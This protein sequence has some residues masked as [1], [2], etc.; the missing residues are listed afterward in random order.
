MEMDNG[1]WIMDNE[2]G[3]L[4]VAWWLAV[5]IPFLARPGW[6]R[7]GKVQTI[8]SQVPTFSRHLRHVFDA[9][10]GVNR[11]IRRKT[12]VGGNGDRGVFVA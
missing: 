10:F 9:I 12:R 1:Q 6:T 8:S 11:D 3:L 2:R 7:P 4:G 5:G